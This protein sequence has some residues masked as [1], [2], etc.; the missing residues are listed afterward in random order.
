VKEDGD[1][2]ERLAA[3]ERVVADLVAER[4][5][6]RQ[7]AG[8]ACA[9]P[10]HAGP[11]SGPGADPDA[12]WALNGL[13]ERAP[14]G[15]VLYVGSVPLPTGERIEW[16]WARTADGLLAADWSEVAAP[17]AALAHPVRLRLLRRVLG[18]AQ[19]TAELADDPELGT[20][21][22]LYHHLRQLTSAGWLH[23]TAR[24]HYTVPGERVVPLLVILMGAQR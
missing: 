23:S 13:D 20:T 10:G 18:G 11:R 22:Q 2:D 5:G 14:D 19:T 4:G 12:F 7:E 21:G 8:P 17:L 3:L 1:F 24:G 9:G 6:G 16:Q 15:A